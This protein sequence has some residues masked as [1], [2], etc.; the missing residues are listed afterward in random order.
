MIIIFALT[1]V[2]FAMLY[3]GPYKNPGWLSTGFAILFLACGFAAMTT[4]EYIRE[5]VRKPYIIYNVVMGNQVLAEEIPV[6]R[7][8]GFLES[9]VWTK[10]FI[11]KNY[12]Q[13]IHENKVDNQ[14][15]LSLP[16][17]DKI[18]IG[19]VLF[20][21]HCNDCHSDREGFSA[22]GR[23]TQSWTPEMVYSLAWEP[24]KAHF[25]MPPWSGT[26]EESELLA[27][28]VLSI[29]PEPLSGMY[30]GENR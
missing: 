20:Q 28:Y 7:A 17:N 3:L 27:E 15:L 8:N 10:A 30:Y 16:E 21:Y 4:G 14:S 12:P 13:V 5:A 1:F 25:F 29:R 19:H 11:A 22:V 24:E 23:L 6:T 9:G 2:V 18:K 26:K